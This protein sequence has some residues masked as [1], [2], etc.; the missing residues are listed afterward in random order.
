MMSLHVTEPDQFNQLTTRMLNDEA[1]YNWVPYYVNNINQWVNN[2]SR[3]DICLA[4]S[5]SEEQ[6]GFIYIQ[7]VEEYK[8]LTLVVFKENRSKGYG[9][10]L[11]KTMFLWLKEHHHKGMILA[12]VH[13]DNKICENLLHKTGFL[14]VRTQDNYNLFSYYIS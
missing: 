10:T 1:S 8:V 13:N 9:K 2:H 4:A 6:I 3:E 14:P 5:F 11:L 12:N 7:T